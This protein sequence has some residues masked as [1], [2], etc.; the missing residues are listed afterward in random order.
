MKETTH[1]ID[2]YLLCTVKISIIKG[3]L[4]LMIGTLDVTHRL[5]LSFKLT[6][7]GQFDLDL[8]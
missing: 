7:L 6:Q 5:I 3:N 1:Y 4:F 8:I 2:L